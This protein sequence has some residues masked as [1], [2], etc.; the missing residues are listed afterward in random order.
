MK[1]KKTLKKENAQQKKR[2]IEKQKNINNK[3]ENIEVAQ[4]MK[5]I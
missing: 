3:E 4:F 1:T 5:E 2:D